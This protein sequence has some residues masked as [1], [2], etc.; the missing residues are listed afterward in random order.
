M[1]Q[2][3]T[4][5]QMR[6]S[7][8]RIIMLG[9]S[10][11][12][13]GGISA[14]INIYRRAGLFDRY[15]VHYIATHIDRSVS[16]KLV[17]VARAWVELMYLLLRGRVGLLHVHTASNASFWR[18][19]IFM[20]PALCMRVPTILH[21][22]GGGFDRFYEN[23]CG[24][25]GKWMIRR[26]FTSVSDVV[27]L[28]A[29]WQHWVREATGR[30]NVRVVS[31]PVEPFKGETDRSAQPRMEVL[32][33]GRLTQQKG[34]YDLIEAVATLVAKYPSMRLVL[35]G[36]GEEDGARQAARRLGIEQ[37]VEIKGWV[38]GA[39]KT[40]LLSSASIFALPSYAEGLPVSILEAMAAGLP[41]IS[42]PVGGIPEAV[43]DGVEG[44]L[45]RPG[46]VSGLA[47]ALDL[48]LGNE[49]LR[50]NMGLAG[51]AK[52]DRTF[53]VY[54]TIPKIEQMYREFGY[55]TV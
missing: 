47:G 1:Q 42:T 16:R 23:G 21:L 11:E 26:A 17:L 36:D 39:S 31:N 20:V 27:V 40:L 46:D 10:F 48:L 24:R 43:S 13:M 12:T 32:C 28:S 33:L 8:K 5:V 49:S 37:H 25:I 3:L 6:K 52:V 44:F 15:P 14:V 18:K 7:R 4:K 55:K 9:T 22:H 54:R 30:R 41:V 29:R 19:L 50:L 38:T 35:G 53:A 45:V 34:T 51:L 2:S